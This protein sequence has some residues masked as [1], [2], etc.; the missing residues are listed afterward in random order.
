MCG[1]A[2]FFSHTPI[3]GADARLQGMAQCIA[4]RGPDGEGIWSDGQIGFAHRRLSII[5]LDPRAGQPMWDVSRRYVIAF[6]GEIYNYRALREKLSALG[7]IFHTD[8]DTEV[9]LNGYAA[10]GT[11][12]CQHLDGMFALA[13][14]DT[15]NQNLFLARDRFGKKPLYYAVLDGVLVFASEL[16]ALKQWPGFDNR[17][18]DTSA[19]TYYMRYQ[20]IAAPQTLYHQAQVF[21]AAHYAMIGADH[22]GEPQ[23]YWQLPTPNQARS[24]RHPP[25]DILGEVRARFTEACR[26]RLVA[27]VPVG[28]WLSGG[29]DSSAVIAALAQTGLRDI[30]TFSIGFTGHYIDETPQAELVAKQFKTD[31]RS[32]QLSP[33]DLLA[34]LP[35]LARVY[36]QPFADPAALATLALS[37]ETARHVKVV[38]T[39]DGGDEAAFGY[40]RYQALAQFGWLR[41][42]PGIKTILSA[43]PPQLTRRN[44]I[45]RLNMLL[46]TKD[47]VQAYADSTAVFTDAE[48]RQLWRPEFRSP[49]DE[50]VKFSGSSLSQFSSVAQAQ[51]K[52]IWAYASNLASGA[53]QVD[54]ARYL[55]DD[56][57]VKVD[58]A[59]MAYG[60]EARAPWLDHELFSWLHSLPTEWLM[61]HGR[62]KFLLKMALAPWLPREIIWRKKQ[63]FELPLQYWLRHEL[64][65]Q[66][67][68]LP[69]SGF[70]QFFCNPAFVRQL[71]QEFESG[72]PYQL[73]LWNLIVFD[74]WYQA[75]G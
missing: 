62:L 10:W 75:Q 23:A 32:F 53:N 40:S 1:I 71:V 21:P 70:A 38:L 41:G 25:T 19:F 67:R 55:P 47:M 35:E 26:K 30:P 34:R 57:L 68:A 45:Q 3:T 74:Y 37:E 17:H 56:L 42:L 36:D 13:I 24:T 54:I 39:G 6:N 43:L 60:L 22:T 66:V 18:W 51:D 52:T 27:D 15:K 44:Q 64:K 5:D 50:L 20:Y 4:H 28:V 73:K 65:A 2:G 8:S 46:T 63:G 14:W 58:R 11:E 29:L 69:E 49:T 7:Y 48:C 59:S 72:K 12:I 61:P 9:I 33:Q 31:H 16:K